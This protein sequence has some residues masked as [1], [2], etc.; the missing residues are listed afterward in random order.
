MES[1][2][3]AANSIRLPT[4]DQVKNFSVP[5]MRRSSSGSFLFFSIWVLRVL[6]FTSTGPTDKPDEQPPVIV[7]PPKSFWQRLWQW[8]LS[9]FQ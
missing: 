4:T 7:E 5:K 1:M 9:L 2:I 3:V 8:L 6:I